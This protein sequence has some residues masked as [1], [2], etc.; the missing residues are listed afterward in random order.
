MGHEPAWR[1]YLRFVRP[2]AAG[3]VTDE[4]EFHI[5]TRADEHVARG[6][7]PDAARRRAVAEMGDVDGAKRECVEIDRRAYRQKRWRDRWDDVRQDARY[8]VRTLARSPAFTSVAV[9]TLALA[10]GATTT[11]FSVVDAV[12]LAPLPVSDPARLVALFESNVTQGVSRIGASGP[13]YLDWHHDAR[14]FSGLAAYRPESFTLTN[15]PSPDVLSGAGVSANFFQVLGVRP[16]LGRTF[17][18]GE[19]RSGAARVVVFSHAAWQRLFGGA[20]DAV[21]RTVILDR[22]PFEVVGVMPSGFAFTS[23]VDA[24]RPADFSRV[25]RTAGLADGQESRQARYIGVVGRLGQGVTV[26]RA[27]QEM[28]TIAAALAERY[29][30]DDRGWTVDVLPLR[31]ALVRTVKPVLVFVFGAVSFVLLIACANVANLTLGRAISREPELALRIAL[32]AGRAR[33]HRQMF[34]ESILIA[35]AGG[36]LGVLLAGAGVRTLGRVLP[37][38]LPHATD[39][40]I[41]GR[42]LL[43]A[44]A[45]SMVTGLLFGLA[46]SLRAA[47]T[48]AARV[49][50]EAGRGRVGGR[51][52]GV[53]RRALVIGEV[54]LAVVLLVGA[55]LTVR[56]VV[57]LL[58]VNPGYATENVIAAHVGLDGDRYQGNRAKAQY[59]RTLME[60]VSALPGVERVGITTTFPLTRAGVDFDLAYRAEGAPE[61]PFQSAPHADYRMISPGYVEAAGMTLLRG[62]TFNAFDRIASDAQSFPDS[63]G[64][65]VGG[66]R[67]MLVNETFARQ[68]WPGQNPIGKHVQLFYVRSEPW[69]VV[70]VVGDTRHQELAVAPRPQVFVP[71]EQGELLFGYGT[72]AVRLKPGAPDVGPALRALGQALDPSEPIYDI[73]TIESLRADATARDRL[74]AVALGA[75]ALLAIVLAAA[76]IYGVIAYQVARRTREIGVRIALGASRTRVVRQVVGEAAM[77]AAVGIAIGAA[78]ALGGTRFARG[79]LFGIAPTDPLTFGSVSA[80]LFGIALAAALVPAMRAARIAPV[81]ALRAD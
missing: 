31:D 24:W 81:E 23:P 59:F 79:M 5:Q 57:K 7:S 28:Q 76:G 55:G 1:R 69:E 78:A 18:P 34:T 77:L 53:A 2:D 32:G 30:I 16:A 62:R 48:T 39:V 20:S 41:N 56:S 64:V 11:I 17:R 45:V 19:D 71:L 73:D 60:R 26:E 38:N 36:T 15:I 61:V 14:S 43:F 21:G 74:T 13:N 12:L 68:N 40:A 70:G 35:L 52:S 51:G 6:M 46:P 27:A 22:Q 42:I 25:A 47:A 4:F 50:Q 66:H 67:V 9:L 37:P 10:I 72:I 33:L 75:F 65:A 49:L 29:P 3:D 63:A 58:E 44:L 8:G 80:L 54:A